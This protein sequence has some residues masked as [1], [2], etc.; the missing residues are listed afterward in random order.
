MTPGTWNVPQFHGYTLSLDLD[1]FTPRLDASKRYTGVPSAVL[2]KCLPNPLV[3]NSVTYSDE[4]MDK[5]L[6]TV[7]GR[8]IN[9]D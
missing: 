4:R 2:L 7:S 1:A 9:P 6:S 8:S 3:M 5:A